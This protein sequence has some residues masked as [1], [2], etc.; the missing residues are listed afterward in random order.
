[1]SRRLWCAECGDRNQKLDGTRIVYER[2]PPEEGYPGD[3]AEYERV[4]WGRAR[5]PRLERAYLV[6]LEFY[7]CDGCNARI[8][9]GARAMAWTL[10][11]EDMPTPPDW[12]WEYLE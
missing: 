7:I 5:R 9:P 11:R 2:T 6:P 3:P 10:W 1:M 12:E 8:D 4:K